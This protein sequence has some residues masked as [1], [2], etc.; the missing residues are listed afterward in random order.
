MNA[1][2]LDIHMHQRYTYTFSNLIMGLRRTYVRFP[3]SVGF[4]VVAAGIMHNMRYVCAFDVKGAQ[5]GDFKTYS[6]D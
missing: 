5:T 3:F 6:I 4:V 2:Q 1:S